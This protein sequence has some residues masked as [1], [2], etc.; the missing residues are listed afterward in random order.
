MPEF[1][2]GNLATILI[3][4][5]LLGLMALAVRSIW[6]DKKQGKSCKSCGGSCS[7]C[8]GCSMRGTKSDSSGTHDR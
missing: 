8:L 5:I 3:G 7:G 1:L 6:R 2:Y 4:L